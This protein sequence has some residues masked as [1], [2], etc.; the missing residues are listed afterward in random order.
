MSRR[1]E[2]TFRSPEG[3]AAVLAVFIVLAHIWSMYR[4]NRPAAQN[5]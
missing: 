5:Q 4:R 2:G 1:T 3:T